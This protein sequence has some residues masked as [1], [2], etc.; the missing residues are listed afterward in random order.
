M[1]E[2]LA[3]ET[4][5]QMGVDYLTSYQT[6]VRLNGQY[7]G[8]FAL[9]VDWTKDSLEAN[10]YVTDPPS[11]LF[12]SESGE[13]SN[14][15]WDIP[16]DQVQ[17]YYTQET[18]EVGR[19]GDS[20]LVQ[21]SKGL[22]GGAGLPRSNFLFEWINLPKTINYM[23]SQTLVVNQDRCT[24]NFLIYLDPSS[25]QWAMLPW[26][27]EG[28]FGIDRGLGGQP[29]PDYCILGKCFSI[30]LVYYC[31]RKLNYTSFYRY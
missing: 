14:L 5:R 26:D 16:S 3:W 19:G 12:K 31:T 21:L 25:Q 17:Y 13:F 8:K 2:T 20:G 28:S 24:K 23:A 27:I 9:G 18:N 29:A 11:S 15:R 22:A 10:G 1:R 6:V 7:F 4:F 30:V